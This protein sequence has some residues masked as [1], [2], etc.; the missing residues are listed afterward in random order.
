[1][2]PTVLSPEGVR[3]TPS[4]LAKTCD[5]VHLHRVEGDER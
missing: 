2:K 5:G 3:C 4:H 1:M